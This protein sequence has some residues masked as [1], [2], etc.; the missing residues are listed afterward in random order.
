MTRDALPDDP[1]LDTDALPTTPFTQHDHGVLLIT[2]SNE[3]KLNAT[4]AAMHA[5]LSRIFRD[6]AD[7]DAINAVVVT[8]EGKAFSAGGDL[9]TGSPS[10]S[11]TT[12]QTMR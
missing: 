1:A 9:S 10:R 12:T 2:L 7:D 11:A 3:G 5:E 8:G 6:I 4:D